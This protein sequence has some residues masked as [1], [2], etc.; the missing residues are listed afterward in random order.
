MDFTLSV[1][2]SEIGSIQ[3]FHNE[4]KKKLC[5]LFRWKKTRKQLG[6]NL[7]LSILCEAWDNSPDLLFDHAARDNFRSLHL[8]PQK[9]TIHLQWF[10]LTFGVTD[11]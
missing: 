4:N 7:F 5:R 2:T 3:Q 11:Q 1:E 6:N 10:R 9:L 8:T